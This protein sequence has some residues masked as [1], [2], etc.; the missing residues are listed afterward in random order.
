MPKLIYISNSKLPATSAHGLQLMQM[1]SAFA[2]NGYDVELVVP[3]RVGTTSEDPFTYYGIDRNFKITKVPCI[4]FIFLSESKLAFL[5]QMLS[6]M[7]FSRILLMF[8]KY[9]VLYSRDA[10]AGVFFRDI[11]L[12]LHS[13]PK[14]TSLA[15]LNILKRAKLLI[16]LTGFIKERMSKL[17]ISKDKILISPDAVN[18][19]KFD[20]DIS[21]DEAR[22]KLGLPADKKLVGYVGML[23]TL[24]MEKGIDVAVKALSQIGRQDVCLVLVG[25]YQPDIEIYEG[26]AELLSVQDRLIC[27]GMV[28]HDLVPIYLK[29][30]DILIAPFPETEHYSY[31][32]SPLK[33]F[34]YMASGRPIISTTLPS[35]K[36]VLNSSNSIL[37]APDSS[38]ELASAVERVLDDGELASSISDKALRDVHEYTWEKRTAKIL[39]FIKEENVRSFSSNS[40]VKE[41]SKMYLRPGEE[42]VIKKYMPKGSVVLDLGCGAGRTTSYIYDNGAKVVGVDIAAPLIEEAKKKFPRIDF[43]VMDA[44]HLDFKDASFDAVFFSFNGIDN[45]DSLEEREGALLEMKRVLKLGGHLIYTSHNGLAIPRTKTS[46][47]IIW[48]NLGRLRIGPHWRVEKYEFGRLTQYYNNI[49]N[50]SFALRLLGF[51]NVENIGNSKRFLHSSRFVLSSVDKFPI[52]IGQK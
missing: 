41:Y 2:K 7:I 20:I 23:R 35:L 29:A 51:K 9:D 22:K 3:R 24:G 30:F 11:S 47:S 33:I 4:D 37:V 10:M 5:L 26:Q 17:G 38:L 52:Y 42:Y 40:S 14:K 48:N 15:Y 19:D 21:K 12:E 39:S 6:F 1:C 27:T 49:W 13:I 32:M 28:K 31:Y 45:L 18:L 25:G 46:F 34:E 43:R 16:V 36:E 8:K 50:E 44:R